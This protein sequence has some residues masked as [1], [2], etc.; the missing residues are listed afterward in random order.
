[1]YTQTTERGCNARTQ[2][3]LL[4]SQLIFTEHFRG[5]QETKREGGGQS[6]LYLDSLWLA[7]SKTV[8]S[9]C[10]KEV[11]QLSLPTAALT[12][13]VREGQGMLGKSGRESVDRFL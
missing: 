4:Y 10:V 5:E 3:P 11:R 9:V 13:R 8:A 6:E 12:N 2:H 1:M 7:E